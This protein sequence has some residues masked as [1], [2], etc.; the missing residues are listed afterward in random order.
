DAGLDFEGEIAVVLGD[1][2]RATTAAEASR[3]VRLLAL[4]N[5]VTSRGLV[6][7][8]LKKGFGFLTSKPATAFAPFAVTP[9]ELGFLAPGTSHSEAD[10]R[11]AEVGAGAGHGVG[12]PAWRGGR[13]S[14]RLECT[15]NGERVGALDTGS[16]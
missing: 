4:V 6:P 7:R 10:V 1:V 14:S 3:H 9:D 2:P 12:F 13:A 8:E 15:L 5:D 16:D 11:P